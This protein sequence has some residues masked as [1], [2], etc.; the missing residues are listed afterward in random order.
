MTARAG[1]VANSAGFSSIHL[2]RLASGRVAETI[3]STFSREEDFYD[4]QRCG[5]GS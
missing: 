1:M 5:M 4:V 3:D 2:Y